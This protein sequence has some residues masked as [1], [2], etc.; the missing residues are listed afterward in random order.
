[1][2][3]NNNETDPGDFRNNR[4]YRPPQFG[5]SPGA[6]DEDR[7]EFDD[8]REDEDGESAEEN[9]DCIAQYKT[10]NP[11]EETACELQLAYD[12]FN[13]VL[14]DGILPPCHLT[15]QRKHGAAG[16]FCASRFING[17]MQ[18]TDE[19]ALNPA[20]FA[21]QSAEEQ[22]ST[23][24]HE[25]THLWQQHFG[26]P[27]RGRYH[28]REWA[29]KMESIGLM[30]SDTGLTDGKKTGDH[31]SDYVITGGLFQQAA[32]FLV[33]RGCEI[34]WRDRAGDEGAPVTTAPGVA[35]EPNANT[36][37]GGRSNRLKFT[38]PGCSQ[39]A[40]AK[41]TARLN[42]GYC[43]ISMIANRNATTSSVAVD[44]SLNRSP[45]GG[46]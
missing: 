11:T 24:V 7:I 39:N 9:A 44:P 13:K 46:K 6:S 18:V 31:M 33:A 45:R 21:L 32:N 3:D 29:E 14:F 30:P 36:K 4:E 37:R 2:K 12:F 22:Y 26:H 15:L 19:I 20:Y 40:W 5:M 38:C 28:N 16:Y 43:S 1:M 10:G 8:L 27:G 35:G 41:P 42:C 23:L 34:T 25:M 17:E